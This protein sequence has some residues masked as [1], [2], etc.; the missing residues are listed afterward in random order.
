MTSALE[1]VLEA[2]KKIEGMK[3][4]LADDKKISTLEKAI[5]EYNK[6][7]IFVA[8]KLRGLS[9]NAGWQSYCNEAVGA[10]QNEIRA[11]TAK[12]DQIKKTQAG[13]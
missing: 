1:K 11:L 3:P 8:S 9:G 2:R 5:E 4:T 12:I 13:T 10:M 7:G 6:F